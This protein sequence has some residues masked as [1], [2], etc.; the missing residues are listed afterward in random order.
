MFFAEA[1][2]KFLYAVTGHTAAEIIMQRADSSKENM[3][4][5]SWD[6]RRVNKADVI[7]AKELLAEG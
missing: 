1:Q 5:T 3:G 7:R 2:N 4:L 6:G